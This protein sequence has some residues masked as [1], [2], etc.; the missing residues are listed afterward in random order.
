[1]WIH[2]YSR[3]S[4]TYDI[5][6][7]FSYGHLSRRGKL[8]FRSCHF[9]MIFFLLCNYYLRD[10]KIGI[11]NS[12]NDIFWLVERNYDVFNILR[13]SSESKKKT[14]E[15]RCSRTW[16]LE[17]FFSKLH[18]QFIPKS[19]YQQ[20]SKSDYYQKQKMCKVYIR[21]LINWTDLWKT[22]KIPLL[23]G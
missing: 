19:K 17:T 4:L 6:I 3:Y 22:Y 16:C 11:H 12:F 8:G 23:I 9:G 1:M 20:I 15:R 2:H 13:S 14:F 7:H 18:W 10:P 21:W 5:D